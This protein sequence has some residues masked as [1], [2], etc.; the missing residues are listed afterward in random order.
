MLACGAQ[1]ARKFT[2]DFMKPPRHPGA[3]QPRPSAS[4]EA[5]QRAVFAIQTGRL[6]EAERIAGQV[7][8]SQPGHPGALHIIGHALL[9]QGRA[10]E[11]VAPLKEAARR[12]QNPA[13]ETQL[14]MAL[15]QS[16]HDDEALARL[17]HAIKRRPPFPPAFLEYGNLLAALGR[18]DEAIAVL[19]DGLQLAPRMGELSI[20][21][22]YIFAARGERA[23]ARA[24]LARGLADAPPDADAT[25]LFA[26]LTQ[27]DGD[28]AQAAEIYRRL[29]A[30][31]PADAAARIGL[32]ICL[33]ECGQAEAGFDSLRLAARAGARMYG[34]AVAALTASGHGRLWLRPSDAERF[35]RAK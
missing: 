17:A 27:D 33:I 10:G 23:K 19:E 28:F 26:R 20:Q 29:L 22:G 1:D 15:R 18:N 14:A 32:G 11:A 35:M 24:M 31:S 4:D 13:A 3:P 21:L 34:E 9:M 30:I 12:T 16:G 6:D 2:L 25:F 8:K 7:L 5:L